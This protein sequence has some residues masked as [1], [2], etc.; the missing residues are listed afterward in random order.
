MKIL[1]DEAVVRQWL[2]WFLWFQ[3]CRDEKAPMTSTQVR[4]SIRQALSDAALYKMA[5]NER[6]LGIQMQPDCDHDWKY[7]GSKRQAM[8]ECTKCGMYKVPDE[9]PAPA[10]PLTDEQIDLLINGRGE[11]GDDDYVE[12]TGDGF[13]LTDADLVRLVRRVEAAHGIKEGGA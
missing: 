6:E 2:E 10:Q 7:I 5:E 4:D 3:S 13:G 9:Q 8:W 1:I 11:E 12:P